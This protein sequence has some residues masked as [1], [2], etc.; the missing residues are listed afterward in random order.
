MLH[1]ACQLGHGQLKKILVNNVS[2]SATSAIFWPCRL[3]DMTAPAC[4][5]AIEAWCRF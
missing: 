5:E 3:A 1:T 4:P 2:A